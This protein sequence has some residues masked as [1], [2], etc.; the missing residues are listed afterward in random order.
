MGNNMGNFTTL[1]DKIL[2]I[3]I[4]L[5]G[6]M[7]N[8]DTS[9]NIF[10]VYNVMDKLDRDLIIQKSIKAKKIDRSRH[11]RKIGTEPR[12]GGKKGRKYVGNRG[13]VKPN[14]SSKGCSLCQEKLFNSRAKQLDA[15][16]I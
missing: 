13:K 4:F 2:Y 7:R 5:W 3:Y 9:I 11:N 16:K 15:K 14:S 8:F 6:T 1:V 12:H 10:S